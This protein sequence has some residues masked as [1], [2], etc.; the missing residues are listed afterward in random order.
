MSAGGVHTLAALEERARALDA[1]DGL[2]PFRDEFH[3]PPGLD[4]RES[5]YLCG[6]SLGLQPRAVDAVLR[7]EL[8]DWKRLAVH[9]HLEGRA[10]WYSYHER[11]LESGAE[12]VGAVPGEVVMMNGLTVN[13]HL[14]LS[15]FYRPTP[16]RYRILMETPAFSSDRY[17]V[18]TQVRMRGIDPEDGL[19]EVGPRAG[20]AV[21]DDADV[22]AR[23]E[24]LGDSLAVVMI[25]GV[26]F[27]N[28]QLFDME[29][30]T[31]A[32]HAVGALV[33]FDLAHAAG[34]VPLAL[35]DWNVDFAA[36]CSYKYLNGGPGAVAGCF[37]HERHGH[38]GDPR[39]GGWWGND[40][41]TRFQ[42]QLLPD[43]VPQPGAAGWQ[44]S[45]PPILAL[46]PLEPSLALFQK[47]GME[48]LRE[49]SLRLWEF[50]HT[51]VR[52]LE[53]RGI[54]I[55]TPLDP[56]RRGCQL[57]LEVPGDGRGLE[58]RLRTRGVVVDYRAPNVIR[59]APVPLYNRF[60]DAWRFASALEA[61]L[62]AG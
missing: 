40:P 38:G 29:A 56:A 42:L 52:P 54:R 36:W 41:D 7:R 31:R 19:V 4:G 35:H 45:N 61:L 32:G 44:L 3:V 6:N 13:L 43:F 28:G 59:V 9:G 37:V 57:S 46:A 48:R 51:C 23:I 60:H 26:N 14:L 49:K 55:L 47:A 39:L 8:E 18:E 62:P 10:P 50:M 17:V 22:L 2:A 53:K 21:I 58:E 11:F 30:I 33:S 20:E 27:L 16:E 15:S 24:E 34:N 5:A 12:L 1:A 25:G